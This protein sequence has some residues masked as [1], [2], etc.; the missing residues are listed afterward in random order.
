MQSEVRHQAGVG[1]CG[2]IKGIRDRRL[3]RGEEQNLRD[4]AGEKRDII[5]E[6]Q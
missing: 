5:G 2:L 1:N 6:W 3:S 4:R